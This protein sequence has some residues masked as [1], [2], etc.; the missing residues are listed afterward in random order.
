MFS[1]NPDAHSV[2]EIDSSTRWG[3]AMAR[4]CRSG[5]SGTSRD[6][7]LSSLA[8]AA[9][10]AMSN[11]PYRVTPPCWGLTRRFDHSCRTARGTHLGVSRRYRRPDGISLPLNTLAGLL[12]GCRT[13]KASRRRSRPE[14]SRSRCWSRRTA[15]SF[16]A[17][18]PRPLPDHHD[19]ARDDDEPCRRRN[20]AAEG[21]RCTA[22]ASPR[23]ARRSLSRAPGLP[24]D[25]INPLTGME[26]KQV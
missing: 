25:T 4:N 3:V 5:A 18:P 11:T 21:D 12:D 7:A 16:R 6:M 13:S 1:I 17:R 9:I 23:A 2:P 15:G 10:V 19:G 26:Y 8:W 20:G 14:R 22:V 24:P